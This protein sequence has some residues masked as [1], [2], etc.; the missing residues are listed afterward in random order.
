MTKKEL[1]VPCPI[2]KVL[3]PRSEEDFPFCSPRC[4]IIDLG[5]WASDGY[6]IKGESPYGDE[7]DLEDKVVH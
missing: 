1:L 3:V 2:C 4:K 6:S 7:D 5:K